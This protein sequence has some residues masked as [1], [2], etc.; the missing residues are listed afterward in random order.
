MA[1][2]S[3]TEQRTAKDPEAFVR[4]LHAAGQTL[5]WGGEPFAVELVSTEDGQTKSGRR[6]FTIR[7]TKGLQL[8]SQGDTVTVDAPRTEDPFERVA[9]HPVERA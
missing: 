9:G 6:R 3:W 2:K 7:I 4:D 5:G 1:Q 8:D